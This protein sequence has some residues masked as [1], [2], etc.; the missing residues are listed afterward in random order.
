MAADID[1]QFSRIDQDAN[2]LIDEAEL[3]VAMQA[4]EDKWYTRIAKRVE[5]GAPHA[6][7]VLERYELSKLDMMMGTPERAAAF[8]IANFDT[9]GDWELDRDEFD[10]AFESFKT[11]RESSRPSTSAS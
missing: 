3:T 1:R 9:D 4:R 10:K 6:D 2:R 11:W 8:L 7:S 5:E